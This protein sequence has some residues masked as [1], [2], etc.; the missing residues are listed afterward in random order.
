MI[1]L[2]EAI[3]EWNCMNC[4]HGL[5]AGISVACFLSINEEKILVCAIENNV[6]YKCTFKCNV[7]RSVSLE[8]HYILAYNTW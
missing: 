2:I 5:P 3:T 6:A 8:I 4:S 1:K 7:G